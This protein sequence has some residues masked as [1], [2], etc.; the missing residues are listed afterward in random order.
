MSIIPAMRRGVGSMVTF[1]FLSLNDEVAQF[2]FVYHYPQAGLL[3]QD[4]ISIAN[5]YLL[6]ERSVF[7][8]VFRVVA[9]QKIEM[10]FMPPRIRR[11]GCVKMEGGREADP[12]SP[13]MGRDGNAE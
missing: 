12:G 3:G 11:R 8:R 1:I 9:F 6:R 5:F 2:R 13:G 10:I 7:N 4:G